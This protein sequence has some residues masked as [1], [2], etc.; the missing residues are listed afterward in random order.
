MARQGTLVVKGYREF[1][2]ACTA[3]QP[4]T[5][6]EVRESLRKVGEVVRIDAMRRFSPI[7]T[8]SAAGYRTRVRQTGIAV[9]QSLKKTTGKHP[10]YGSLQMKRALLPALAANAAETERELERALDRVADAFERSP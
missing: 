2:A 10:H 4:R 3:A 5:R 7:S 6:K 1:M 8:R 9:Q